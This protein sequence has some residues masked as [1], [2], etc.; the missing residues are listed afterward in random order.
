MEGQKIIQLGRKNF[1]EM[2]QNRH[3]L[4]NVYVFRGQEN[5]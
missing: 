3:S 1:L 2:K 5:L 4:Y